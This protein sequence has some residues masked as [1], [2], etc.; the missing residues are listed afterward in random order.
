M[1]RKVTAFVASV[2]LLALVFISYDAGVEAWC[3]EYPSPD[4]NAC[5]GK[6]GLRYCRDDCVAIGH[7]FA[8]GECLKNPDGSFGDCLCLKCADE[9]PA[10]NTL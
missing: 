10:A 5:R 7:G 9:P 3:L 8:G 1:A 6:D 4:I 2:L